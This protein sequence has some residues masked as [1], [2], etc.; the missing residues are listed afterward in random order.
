MNKISILQWIKLERIK[1][2]VNKEVERLLDIETIVLRMKMA[3]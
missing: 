2:I 1:L 3:I